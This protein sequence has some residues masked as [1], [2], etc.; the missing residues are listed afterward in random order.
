MADSPGVNWEERYLDQI[1]SRLGSLERGLADLR[2]ELRD[3]FTS[4]RR[5]M[6]GLRQ[7]MRDELAAH[8]QGTSAG[9]EAQ[10]QEWKQEIAAFRAEMK[11]EIRVLSRQML[12]LMA[13][14]AV[15]VLSVWLKG[16][17]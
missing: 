7:E 5:E 16:L 14:I 17:G 4:V 10:R 6:A 3:E 9:F 15:I 12:G 11:A 2:Q 13:G 8:R 1:E